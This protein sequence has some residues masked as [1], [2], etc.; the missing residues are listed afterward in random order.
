[1][2]P[3]AVLY[4]VLAVSLQSIPVARAAGPSQPIDDGVVCLRHIAA[5][6]TLHGMPAG[7]LAA[8]GY[9]ESGR[10]VDRRQRTV[11]PWTVNADGAGHYFE[12]K[13]AAV[14]F[15]E[16]LKGN[17]VESIDVGCLQI[18]LRHHPG[19][20]GTLEDAF[21]PA[22]NVAY[23]ATFLSALRAE[24]GSWIKAARRY[25]SATP[26]LG[27]A[28]AE[29]VLAAWAEYGEPLPVPPATVVT[30]LDIGPTAL[31]MAAPTVAGTH[32]PMTVDIAKAGMSVT[33]PPLQTQ[34]FTPKVAT[35]M[36][37]LRLDD[38]RG[39]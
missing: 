26:A 12:S 5:A 7:L 39:Q 38:Y 21:D 17:G 18:N 36:T 6:E 13:A 10:T 27:K 37:G 33:A 34:P 22:S 1:M 14:A 2:T 23:G 11:W 35:G 15:V 29:R 28:Y 32:A 8:I 24:T 9:T 31:P 16:R 30:E 25:H 3:R 4:S 20:F 19:A